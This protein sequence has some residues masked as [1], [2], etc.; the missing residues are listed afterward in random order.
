MTRDDSPQSPADSPWHRWSPIGETLDASGVSGAGVPSITSLRF[1]PLAEMLTPENP[2]HGETD[3]S[4]CGHC[5]P[6]PHTIWANDTWAVRSGFAVPGL[7]FIATISPRA[8]VLLE[9]APLDVLSAMGPVLQRVSNAVK[10]IPGVARC[11]L[12]RWN[13]GSAHLHLWA[14]ARPEGMMQ[15]RGAILPFWEQVLPAMPEEM[16][17]EHI[18]IVARALEASG[19]G[20]YY[21]ERRG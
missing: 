20:A 11:H 4:E 13:D 12:M 18:E 14:Y 5:R 8:H 19:D 16:A 15:G 6:S 21:P 3:P 2:R 1:L 7:P 9:S 10:R 17:H